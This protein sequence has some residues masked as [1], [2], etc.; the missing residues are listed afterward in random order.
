MAFFNKKWNTI[1]L[2]VALFTLSIFA[3]LYPPV[4]LNIRFAEKFDPENA[5]NKDTGMNVLF[6]ESNVAAELELAKSLQKTY[7][8][9]VTFHCYWDGELIEKH[10][11]SLRSC[12]YY[13]VLNKPHSIVLWTTKIHENDWL[14]EAQKYCEIRL[15]NHDE[16]KS[17]TFLENIDFSGV[18][19]NPSFFSDVVR[20]TLLYKYGGCWFDLDVFFL[21]SLDP[22]FAEYPEEICVYQWDNQMHPNGAIFISL[23][24]NSEKM[25]TNIEYIS[26]RNRGWG[27]QEAELTFDLPLK[28]LVLP[29]SWFDPYWRTD[30]P[31]NGATF[32]DFFDVSNEQVTFE[33]FCNGAFTFHWH[34]Q[35]GKPVVENTPIFMLNDIIEKNLT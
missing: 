29:C 18:N 8:A 4:P 32:A 5:A 20:Y 24:P 27:F 15:Y 9:P 6:T 2:L 31:Y 1:L 22:I 11:I 30:H 12:Y 19:T 33:N 26:T 10:V 28:M 35:W 34:N 16:E 17:G 3:A 13:N 25:K 23:I 14:Q 21:R 7:D